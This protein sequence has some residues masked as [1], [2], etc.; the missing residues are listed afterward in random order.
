MYRGAHPSL[1][2][3]R[4]MRRLNLR[5]IISLVPQSTEGTRDLRDYCAGEQIRHVTHRVDKYDDEFSH[6]PALIATILSDV[7][8]SR[9]HPLFLHCRDGG[10]NT[11]IVIMCLRRL[12]N[13]SLPSIYNEFVRY[14]KSNYI[15]YEEK[16]FVESFHAT[17]VVPALIPLWLWKGVRH[18]HHP[19]I[20]LHLDR[21]TASPVSAQSPAASHG[22]DM[23]L[24]LFSTITASSSPLKLRYVDRL[25]TP[26]N[27]TN[28]TK[29]IESRYSVSLAALDLHG[30]QLLKE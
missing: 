6:T 29:R 24:P 4:F 22:R 1:K 20:P 28:S 10:H 16:Q 23:D 27:Q 9:N 17:V 3:L 30:V 5:T 18:H 15:S 2:N 13:W 21:D 11:G 25:A 8:D 7:I 26:S 19:S 14:T 12:Q